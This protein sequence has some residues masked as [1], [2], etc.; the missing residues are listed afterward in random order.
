MPPK[1]LTRAA[2]ILIL[3]A[4]TLAHAEPAQDSA[5]PRPSPATAAPKVGDKLDIQQII[6]KTV[7]NGRKRLEIR[8][9]YVYQEREVEE[10]L[11]KDGSV[12][13]TEIHTHEHLMVYG[14]PYEKL[15]ATDDK[16]LPEDRARKEE[17]K[18]QK[19]YDEQKKRF[20]KDGDA[21]QER[22]RDE[23]ERKFADAILNQME[24]TL[25]GEDEVDGR[26]V[27]IV[28]AE[29]KKQRKPDN[30]F[31]KAVSKVRGK[32]W[33]DQA[34]YA[35]VRARIDVIDDI[36]IGLFLF[37]LHKGTQ[38]EF[39][40]TRVNDELWMPRRSMAVGSGRILMFTGRFRDESTYSNFHRF[41]TDSKVIGI[42]ADDKGELAKPQ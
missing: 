20:E 23:N 25:A 27:W 13:K 34:D 39:E 14:R 42:V 6:D 17:E 11:N 37:R 2:L 15:I 8:R 18:F 35:W 22:K 19:F 9:N 28:N 30:L 41:K 40:Q 21:R 24:F 4:V 16:P 26:P 1:M 32:L 10:E 36:A 38:I 3:S 12:K 29:P 33:I 7:E 31:E 5:A